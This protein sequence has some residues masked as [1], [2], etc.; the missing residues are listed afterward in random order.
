VVFDLG[1][2]G[3]TI[4][5]M[6]QLHG[7]AGFAEVFFDDVRIPLAGVVGEV[8]GGWKVAQ[9][10]LNL[11]RGS[12]R[13]V[14]TRLNRSLA[15]LAVSVHAARPDPAVL[16]RLGSLRAWAFAYEQSTYALTDE[17]SR[18]GDGGVLPS[19]NKLRLSEIQTAVH[20]LHL[21]VL[22]EAAEIVPESGP[23]GELLGMRRD[24]WHSRAQ[25][26]YAGTTEIQKNII[27]ERGLGLPREVRP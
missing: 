14:H 17:L 2:P 18:G 11:E 7:H 4:R 24:Y 6:R 1:V 12:A 9:T 27:A 21:E 10:A 13:G 3:V 5:P 20:E 19:I 22:G 16:G 15:D 26:I 25:E 8:N 23:F